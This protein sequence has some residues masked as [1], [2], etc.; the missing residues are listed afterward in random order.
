M[1]L[2]L[3]KDQIITLYNSVFRGYLNYYSFVNNYGRLAGFLYWVLWMSCGRLIAAK[4]STTQSK[5]IAKYGKLYKGNDK[6]E[7]IYPSW[8]NKP[9]KF[10]SKTK[11]PGTNIPSLVAS[12][13]SIAK[14]V[15]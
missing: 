3:N 9:G 15:S 1:W 6:I 4:H 2:A 7:F 11:E 12:K 5:I 8:T 13:I 10:Y 14:R